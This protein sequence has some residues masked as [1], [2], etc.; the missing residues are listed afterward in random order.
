MT[1]TT[2]DAQAGRNPAG[3]LIAF[4]IEDELAKAKNHPHWA[5]NDRFA[6]S[7]VK[8]RDLT[9]TLMLMRKGAHLHEHQARGSV[10]VQVLSGAIRFKARN[11]ERELTPGTIAVLDREIP[12]AVEALAES[13]FILTASLPS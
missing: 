2:K 3:E 6:H 10:T 7:L 5:S 11:G 4:T 1:D 12:H 8:H 9:V 13:A